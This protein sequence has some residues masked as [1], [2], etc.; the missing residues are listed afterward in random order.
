MSVSSNPYDATKNNPDFE[1]IVG[2][3]IDALPGLHDKLAVS[4]DNGLHAYMLA[5]AIE[6][7]AKVNLKR[8]EATR[9]ATAKEFEAVWTEHLRSVP[10]S[11]EAIASDLALEP[12][13]RRSKLVDL[14]IPALPF[15]M[16]H[17]ESGEE[18][19][20]SAVVELT[21]HTAFEASPETDP[22]EWAARHKA[23]LSDLKQYVLSR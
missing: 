3:G 14:G 19:F 15:L 21:K 1:S 22:K 16:D 4:P 13:Q 20:F 23:R 18:P 5:I 10:A 17:V 6:T 12:E 7:I 9:W 11:V 2:L 8:A